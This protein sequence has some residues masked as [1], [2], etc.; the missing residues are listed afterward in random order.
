VRISYAEKLYFWTVGFSRVF[1][2]TFIYRGFTA[3]IV[4][5]NRHKYLKIIEHCTDELSRADSKLKAEAHL[6][7]GTFRYLWGYSESDVL[8]DLD[9]ITTC[10]VPASLEIQ[11]SAWI[12]RGELFTLTKDIPEIRKSYEQAQSLSPDNPDTYSSYS[13]SLMEADQLME[14][15]IQICKAVEKSPDNPYARKSLHSH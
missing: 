14:A 15:Y 11:T 12:K 13:N 10:S 7:R 8:E 1:I 2:D 5:L 9:P 3:A 4:D 6:L